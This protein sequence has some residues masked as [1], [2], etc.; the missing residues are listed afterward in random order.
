M[1]GNSYVFV[2]HVPLRESSGLWS[3]IFVVAFLVTVALV[4]Y[5]LAQ[6]ITLPIVRLRALTSEFSR[7][8]FSA[9]VTLGRI[10]ERKDEIGGLARDF[11][12]MASRIETL[13]NAQ[14]RLI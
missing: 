8:D 5:L 13:M 11:N 4:C 12:V 2:A 10:L 9:R 1:A 6:N 3:R 7:G 14:Q